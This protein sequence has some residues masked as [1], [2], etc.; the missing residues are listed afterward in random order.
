MNNQD[1]LRASLSRAGLY[2]TV[3]GEQMAAEPEAIEYNKEIVRGKVDL[4][5]PAD[6]FAVAVVVQGLTWPG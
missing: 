4:L 3:K 6:L 5:T 1:Q 2:P